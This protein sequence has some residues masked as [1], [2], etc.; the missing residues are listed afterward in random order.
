[1]ANNR[2]GGLGF[3]LK[4][5]ACLLLL[6]TSSASRAQQAAAPPASAESEAQRTAW[7]RQAKFGMFI[8]WGP[9]SLASVEASWPI[10]KPEPRW[11]IT[12]AEY[13]DLYKR[14]NPVQFDPQAWVKLATDAG[15]RYMVFTAK[16][17]D[18]FCMFNTALT[19]YQIT[20]TPYGKNVTTMLAAAAHNAHMPIGFYYSPP[21]MHHSGFR[22]TS[23]P[24]KDTWHGDPTR[25]QWA[26]YLDYMDAQ[27]RELLTEYGPVSLI[28]FDGLDHPEKY[29]GAEIVNLVHHIQPATLVNDRIGVPGDF[30]TPEQFIPDRIP[31]K[32]TANHLHAAPETPEAT[33]PSVPAPDDFQLWETCMTINGTWAYN[34][35][36]TQYKSAKELI[37]DLANVASKGGN[38]LLDVGPT[39]EGTIQ[40]EFVDRLEGMGKWLKV[41]GDSI[42]GTTY[43]PLQNLNFGKTTAKDKIVYLHVF[44]W[45]TD[46]QLEV[47]GL[48]ARVAQITV[49]GD[50]KKLRWRQNS[51]KL[52]IEVPPTAPDPSDTVLQIVTR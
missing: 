39:P 49:L 40:P 15:M 1:M 38:L 32:S 12:E 45:P 43:G 33:P 27:V 21:D 28:W 10:M 31:T 51:E 3:L 5:T 18:G 47:P 4:L 23:K 13:V 24:V 16:H 6:G 36:D 30:V 35:N 37:Q 20:K 19:S 48:E 50:K 44:D 7:F 26:T 22:D 42:Y 11:N 2:A 25:P 41:Y 52:V 46:S 34:K 14:F 17:H 9:Y 29:K 8:H